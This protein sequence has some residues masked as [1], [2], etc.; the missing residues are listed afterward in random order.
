MNYITP[1]YSL[2][3][4]F[5]ISK[6]MVAHPSCNCLILHKQRN[7]YLDCSVDTNERLVLM[8]SD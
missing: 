7:K 3:Y 6:K 8:T 4:V 1:F 2:S 5:D